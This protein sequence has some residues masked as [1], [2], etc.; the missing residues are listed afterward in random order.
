MPARPN[1]VA[2][3]K[4]LQVTSLTGDKDQEITIKTSGNSTTSN[5][6]NA[7][8]ERVGQVELS[9]SDLSA[10]ATHIA[11]AVFA[12][13]LVIATG[14][15]SSTLPAAVMED[16]KSVGQGISIRITHLQMSVTRELTVTASYQR[17]AE[18][19]DS[20]FIE[21]VMA[22]GEKVNGKAP[23]L[24]GGRWT[25]GDPFGKTG[26]LTAKFKLDG[27]QTHQSFRF[28]IVTESQTKNISIEV[29]N[30]FKR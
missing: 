26:S 25:D 22:L 23:I 9:K 27:E 10:D 20:P 14:R 4:R 17:L 29:K 18:G 1:Y 3:G 24:G 28:D 12:T 7:I 6:Y 19:T 5:R 30:I 8:H 16:F 15:V 11:K 13:N 2:V 21:K